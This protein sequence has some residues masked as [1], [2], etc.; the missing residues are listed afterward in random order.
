[1][2]YKA[3]NLVIKFFDD[4]SSK[5]SETKYKTIHGEGIKILILNKCFKDLQQNMHK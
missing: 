2:L 4:Y 3:R 1:M 5:I